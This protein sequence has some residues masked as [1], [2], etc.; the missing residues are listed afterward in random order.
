MK[1]EKDSELDQAT[2]RIIVAGCAL[3]W[4]RVIGGLP[5]QEVDPYGP[6]MIYITLFMIGWIDV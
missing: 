4:F 1:V 6:V 2:L 3:V 5:G